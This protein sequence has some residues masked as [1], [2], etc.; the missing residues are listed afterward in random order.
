MRAAHSRSCEGS[1]T[2]GAVVFAPKRLGFLD[3]C[4]ASFHATNHESQR[5]AYPANRACK[6]SPCRRGGDR[7]QPARLALL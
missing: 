7:Y 1:A 5:R 2:L 6:A 3:E 4:P